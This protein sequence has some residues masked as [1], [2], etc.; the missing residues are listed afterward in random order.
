MEINHKKI[1]E[2]IFHQFREYPAAIDKIEMGVMTF[3]YRVRVKNNN[4][5]LRIYPPENTTMVKQEFKVMHDLFVQGCRV[6]EPI[7]YS[8]TAIDRFLIYKY[9][10]GEPLSYLLSSLSMEE[11]HKIA[12]QIMDNILCISTRQVEKFGFLSMN[13]KKYDNWKEFLQNYIDQAGYY[14][15]ENKVFDESVI[16]L[17]LDFARKQFENINIKSPSFTWCDFS[18]SNIIIKAGNLSGF[19]DFEGCVAGDPLIALGYLFAIEG[20]SLFFNAISSNYKKHYSFSYEQILFYAIIRL[21]RLSKYINNLFPTG[22]RRDPLT[23]FYKG[24]PIA[25]DYIKSR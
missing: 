3:K 1:Q 23:V 24:L 18:Q 22:I 21:F 6:P 11:L 17:L 4:Y 7:V 9:I 19:I 13:E 15:L 5:I 10:D 14:L 16:V 12:G 2:I 8:D 25:V 20:N